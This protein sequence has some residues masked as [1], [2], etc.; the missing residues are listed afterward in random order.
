MRGLWINAHA[1]E[2]IEASVKAIC[3]NQSWNEGWMAV[4]RILR[5]DINELPQDALERVKAL[6]EQLKPK[7]LEN[8]ARAYALSEKPFLW[9]FED[10]LDEDSDEGLSHLEKK[11]REIASLV[12]QDE[13]VLGALLPEL[14]STHNSRIFNFGEGF[15]EGCEN[16][17]VSKN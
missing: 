1:Y 6:R 12:A 14:V 10:D 4:N 3:E 17:S 15:A 13:A 9:N 11:T 16:K 8:L 2:A 5:Y 7:N